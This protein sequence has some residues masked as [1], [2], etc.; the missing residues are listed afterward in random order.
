MLLGAGFNF[1]DDTASLIAQYYSTG[2]HSDQVDYQRF[3]HDINTPFNH[4]PSKQP[5]NQSNLN[6]IQSIRPVLPKVK[7]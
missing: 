4:S 7:Q 6:Q 2:H 3:L 1:N 5:H